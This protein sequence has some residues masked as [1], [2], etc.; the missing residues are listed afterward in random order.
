MTGPELSVVVPARGLWPTTRACLE[1]LRRNTPGRFE[2]FLIDGG[3]PPAM[4]RALAAL[5][6]DWPALTVLPAPRPNSY[7]AAVNA[8]ARAARAPVLVWLNNDAFVTPGWSEALREALSRPG[9]GAAGPR[10]AASGG[11]RVGAAWALSRQGRVTPVR[12]LNGS[13]LAVRRE[14]ADSVGPLDERFVW[15]LED[16]DYCFR[17][18]QAGWS[19]VRADGAL[20][21]HRSGATRGRWPE[22]RRRELERR[23]AQ[24]LREKWRAAPP[25]IRRD[26]RRALAGVPGAAQQRATTGRTPRAAQKRAKT[27][28]VR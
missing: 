22:A 10:L 2:V 8:G 1:A 27:P 4:V 21:V 18:R 7:S 20:V 28:A 19:L 26:L 24:A 23:N 11:D 12:L 13:C 3:S 25:G 16:Y 5:A 14:A 15:D 17:L 9:V 6:R